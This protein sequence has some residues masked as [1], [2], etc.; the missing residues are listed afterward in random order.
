MNRR[1]AIASILGVLGGSLVPVIGV[2]YFIDTS[3][4]NTNE[5]LRAHIALIAELVDVIIPPTESPGAKDSLVHDYVVDYM[6]NCASKKE[7]NNFINGII[8]L[9]EESNIQFKRSFENCSETQK[10]ELIEAIAESNQYTGLLLKINNKLRGRSFF[11]ILKTLT[12]EGY[13]TSSNGA[14]MHLEYMP[15]PGK[16]N[17]ITNLGA[18][19]KAWATK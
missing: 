5:A 4:S 9:Q 11:N 8:D 3:S 12:I 19:Q 7:Y 18:H 10:I 14:T 16:Y 1:K 6:E 13:C 2:K 15:V 17:P